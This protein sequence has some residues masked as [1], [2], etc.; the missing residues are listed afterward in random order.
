[1]KQPSPFILIGL[2]LIALIKLNEQPL[3]TTVALGVLVV[4]A[5][6]MVGRLQADLPWIRRQVARSPSHVAQYLK[7]MRVLLAIIGV[8]IMVA[9]C[10]G[11]L[12]TRPQLQTTYLPDAFTSTADITEQRGFYQTETD[13]SG[14][15]YVWTQERATLVFDFL[16]HRPITITFDMRSAAVAGGPDTPVR[17]LVN[18]Q[19]VGVIRPDPKNTAFQPFSLRIVPYNWGGEQTEIKLVPQTFR[20]GRGDNRILGTMV[21]RITIDKSEAWSA[22]G[23]RIWLIGILPLFALIALVLVWVARRFR[24]AIVGYG[25]IAACVMG[26][27]CA[28][29]IV[30]LVLR[31]GFIARS[32]YIIWVMSGLCIAIC[33][34]LGALMLPFGKPGARSL[35]QW[36]RFAPAN[37]V[38]FAKI[39]RQ[40]SSA[41]FFPETDESTVTRR[42]IARDLLLVFMVALG[43]RLIWV[44]VTPPWQAPDEPEHYIYVKH[45]VEQRRLPY[46]PDLAYPPYSQEDTTDWVYTLLRP[47]SPQIAKHNDN[48]LIPYV[49]FD[50]DYATARAYKT[51]P[52]DRYNADG[53]RA[54]S[55]P[56]L[57]Y[58]AETVPY[59][60]FKNAPVL[61]RLY[62]VRCGS[63]VMGALSCVFAYL[64]AYQVRRTRYWGWTLG[65]CMALMPMY[66]FITAT[67]NNDVGMDLCATA[68]I[69][70]A[71]RAYQQQELSY[72][73]AVALGVTSGLTLLTK[74]TVAPLVVMVGAV[75]LVK[76][77][78]NLRASWQ[79]IQPR[80]LTLGAYLA[81]VFV[82]YG[83]YMLFRLRYSGNGGLALIAVTRMFRLLTGG[84]RAAA[85]PPSVTGNAAFLAPHL[86][87]LSANISPWDYVTH[88]AADGGVRLYYLFIKAFWGYLGWLD[89]PMPDRYYTFVFTFFVISSIGLA[90]QLVLQPS[91]RGL[92]LLLFGMIAVQVVSLYGADYYLS[93]VAGTP[94]GL[95]GRYFF[96]I[97]APFL[98]LLL[99]GWDHLF[100]GRRIGLRIAVVLMFGAQ[101]AGLV[102][103][104]ARYYGVR[105]G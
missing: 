2:L 63:A 98:L 26:A 54:T 7:G 1:M 91:R 90:I 55:Y 67:V 18:G 12:L 19:D 58:L 24:S 33:F 23:R 60:L 37:F 35:L 40:W 32:T 75:L 34:T 99:S 79:Q 70:L 43:I 80:F 73:L 4:I 20:P 53:G 64:L 5:L 17:V 36:I 57:Y 72:P 78:A 9:G 82:V 44:F 96:P 87:A 16:V 10:G 66:V 39:A 6:V 56:P 41:F 85:A 65:L 45:I 92:L 86:G 94:L 77:I 76:L 81:T 83:P 28:A 8:S 61:F 71:V 3:I 52:H 42:Q 47:L 13:A 101:L 97:L 84:T 15:R 100:R 51:D 104:F 62:A 31:I 38:T 29:L 74:P 25:A 11:M 21:Q 89:T 69:W 27:L 103:M 14:N 50:Y 49:P 22:I 59:A 102:T 68:L 88:L 30:F 48:L 93:Y 95:Q 46:P 105:I